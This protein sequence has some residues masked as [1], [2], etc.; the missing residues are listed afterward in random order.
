MLQV[1]VVMY[2]ARRSPRNWWLP[3]TPIFLALAAVFLVAFPYLDAGQI[4]RPSSP[5]LRQDVLEDAF[6]R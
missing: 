3:V 6:G 4:H 1:A 5:E 2:F